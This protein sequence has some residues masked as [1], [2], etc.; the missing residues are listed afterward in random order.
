MLF[1]LETCKTGYLANSADPDEMTTLFAKKKKQSSGK[2]IHHKSKI[3]TC[4][5]LNYIMNNS[6]MYGKINKY[7]RG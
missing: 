7:K 5:P 3:L 6:N 4:D 2:E 1:I